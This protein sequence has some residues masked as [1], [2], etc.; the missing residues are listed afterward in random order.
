ITYLAAFAAAVWMPAFWIVATL[1]LYNG[2][3]DQIVLNAFGLQQFVSGSVHYVAG[4]QAL[5]LVPLLFAQAYRV[6]QPA[7][8]ILLAVAAGLSTYSA[9]ISGARAVYLPLAV[10][11]ALG[12]LRFTRRARLTSLRRLGIVLFVALT[13]IVVL[14]AIQPSRPMI[15]ALGL[16]A[17]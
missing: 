12:A 17:S 7:L 14:E 3:F 16:K 5:V 9:L 8:R 6:R 11:F 2:L 1:F 10:V 13:T 15:T 4:A